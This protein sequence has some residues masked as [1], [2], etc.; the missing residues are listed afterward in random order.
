MNK[1]SLKS[2]WPYAVAILIMILV[3]VVFFL[4]Q[5][6]GEMIRQ[7]D[8]VLG[9][10]RVHAVKE[11]QKAN[12]KTYIWNPAIFG[13]MPLL[14]QAPSSGNLIFR[15]YSLLKIGFDEPIGLYLAGMIMGFIM[16]LA[17]GFNPWYSLLFSIPMVFATD[18]LILWEAGHNSKIR[19]LIFTPLLIAGVLNIFERKKYL[20]GGILLAVGFSM[21]TT[22]RHPQM[23]YYIMLVFMI[24]GF[25]FLGQTIKTKDWR[26]L[27][28]GT[29]LA[30]L[31]IILGMAT[32]T[33][34]L[35]SLYNYSHDTMR[36][37]SIL[38]TASS[39]P[40]SSS[41]VDGLEW[42]YAMQWSNEL[43][44]IA[45]T[46]I[47]GFAGG[48]SGEKVGTSSNVYRT[49]K[50]EHAPLYWGKLPITSGPNYL[51]ASVYFL[52][53]LGL[54]M[55]KG[56]VKWWLGI[57]L[58]WMIILSMGSNFSILNKFIFNYFPLYSKFRAPSS[59]LSIASFF[60]P[61][62]GAYGLKEF[63]TN[64]KTKSKKKKAERAAT[65]RKKLFI[66]GG[67]SLVIP[68]FFALAGTSI[69]DF[70]AQS[71][72]RLTSQGADITPFIK[73][74]KA[75]FTQ[76]C[77]R[78]VMIVLVLCG[79]LFANHKGK[80]SEHLT[81]IGV[82]IVILIDLCGVNFRYISHDDYQPSRLLESDI[83]ARDVDKQILATEKERHTYRVYD[84]TSSQ[85]F[86]SSTGAPFHNVIGGYSPV[87]MQR[88]DDLISRHLRK[89]NRSALD[90]LNV[91]YII[92]PGSDN[93]PSVQQSPGA[94]GPAWYVRDVD[95]VSTP[96]EE[97]DALS[98]LPVKTKAVMLDKDFP[99]YTNG[100]APH[101]DASAQ[102][103][104]TS[105]EPD[106]I[107]YQT[108]SSQEGM[109]AF[110]E[111]W[112]GPNKGWQAYIDDE[113]VDHVRLNYVLRGLRVPAGSHKVRFE[114][115][116]ASV[117]LGEGVSYAS[118]AILLLLIGGLIF[119]TYR[120]STSPISVIED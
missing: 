6:Q 106:I 31:A 74:R 15:A 21:S 89:V 120:D 115:S 10:E 7:G 8:I 38:A 13:G 108:S 40:Q 85:P 60:L 41:E 82:G 77:W 26:H 104:I 92:A 73:D 93:R 80:I 84:L 105:Y 66:A 62:L 65:K 47:P 30:T 117:R 46:Y 29:G 75:L 9:K 34:K 70:S 48:G 14:D 16:F 17:L 110:S 52:F 11:Y 45:A 97:I 103:T 39:E 114:F 42:T 87:K 59:V 64:K 95:L 12:G 99:G 113:P 4:P 90:M 44:D 25:V 51:G 96:N 49:Y 69:F 57:G 19:T 2:A 118:S 20:L 18:N 58:V 27:G 3:N 78:T 100:L 43:K 71:D 24:Y 1:I 54:L 32:S 23:T 102:V 86:S 5:L 76:D 112:F 111:I 55:K 109:I 35:W 63:L 56:N 72:A 81:L 79:L 88:I 68:L 50:M 116:P 98:G 53:L 94:C 36:G 101:T 119:K 91:K 37:K 67:I 28:I 33:T 107:S 83:V 22:T 61:L